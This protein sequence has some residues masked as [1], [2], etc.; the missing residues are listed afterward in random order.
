MDMDYVVLVNPFDQPIGTLSKR[1]AHIRLH[2]QHL[3]PLHRSFSLNT[4]AL[5]PCGDKLLMLLTKRAKSKITFPDLYT[6]TCC[7]HPLINIL[8]EVRE[9]STTSS[10]QLLDATQEP[11][12]V[13]KVA[14]Q[15]VTKAVQRK[16]AQELGLH[17]VDNDLVFVRR[18]HY[19]AVEPKWGEH[20]MDYLFISMHPQIP[21]LQVNSDEVSQVQWVSAEELRTML[22][23]AP[24]CFTPWSYLIFTNMI[25]EWWDVLERPTRSNGRFTDWRQLAENLK[26]DEI[27]RYNT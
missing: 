21:S 8:N 23:D 2:D 3:L 9:T 7:S 1:N 17:L 6:N 16:A 18:M 14:V 24:Q 11:P 19:M 22:E 13:C 20:E 4:F 26:S 5:S 15:D 25:F 27:I 10:Q 12:P